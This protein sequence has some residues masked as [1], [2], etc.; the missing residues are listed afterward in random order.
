MILS[1]Q[2]IL[3]GYVLTALMRQCAGSVSCRQ[4]NRGASTGTSKYVISGLR[5]SN[6]H[7]S[8][9]RENAV[10]QTIHKPGLLFTELNGII[11]TDIVGKPKTYPFLN[12]LL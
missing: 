5:L 1:T 10:W 4:A 7:P 9:S 8:V 11:I 12:P 6:G 3:F 2:N